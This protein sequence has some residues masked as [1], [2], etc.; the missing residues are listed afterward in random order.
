MTTSTKSAGDQ[1]KSMMDDSRQIWS[2]RVDGNLWQCNFKGV[3][4][5]KVYREGGEMGYVP[6]FAIYDNSLEIKERVNG[7]MVIEVVYAIN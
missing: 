6:W 3:A 4:D 5:I 2:I 1:P 7:K